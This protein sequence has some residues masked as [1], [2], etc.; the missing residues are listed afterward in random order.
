M[1]LRTKENNSVFFAIEKIIYYLVVITAFF[2]VAIFSVKLGAWTMFPFRFFL[3]LLWILFFG[4]ILVKKRKIDFLKNKIQWYFIFLSFW[5]GYALLSLAWAASLA[6]AV[7]N[8]FFLFMGISIIFFSFYYLKKVEDYQ[9]IQWIWFGVFSVLVIL[10]FWEHLTGQHLLL[11][12][13]YGET[14]SYLMFRPTGIFLNQNDYATFLSLSIPFAI[15]L[16]RDEDRILFSFLGMEIVVG[17]I[18][19]IVIT[20]SRANILAILLE[21]IIF[22]IIVNVK[23]KI[24]LI[25][26]F[27][28]CVLILLMFLSIPIQ[29]FFSQTTGQISS[30]LIQTEKKIGTM[31]TRLN[32]IRNGLF[33]LNSKA[34]FGVGAGNF[35]YYMSNFAIY[36]TKGIINSHNWWLEMLVNYGVFIFVSYLIFYFSLIKKLRKIYYGKI[37]RNEKR[38]CEG[39]LISLIGF[40]FASFGPS[41]IIAFKP[42]WLLF[43]FALSFLNYILKKEETQALL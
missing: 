7:R 11:S 23:Q 34:G 41:S 31:P 32:L 20:A 33:F 17:A 37:S 5:L 36:D 15:S 13:Y 14:S 25:L 8:I 38:I 30:V 1:I 12:R 29:E 42:Q 26:T 22:L 28:V 35:E 16:F 21:L 4:Y 43:A 19:L 40:S 39:L 24:K 9:K 10:G 27:T 6:P 3:L 2:G 18:Y